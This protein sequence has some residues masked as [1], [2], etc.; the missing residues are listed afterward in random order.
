M[1]ALSFL[2]DFPAL[3]ISPRR[4]GAKMLDFSGLPKGLSARTFDIRNKDRV[5]LRQE[6][7]P[8][9]MRYLLLILLLAAGCESV[10]GPLAPRPGTR[11]DDPSLSIA[12]QQRQGRDRIGLP[13]NSPVLPP[14]AGS[15]PGR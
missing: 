8:S 3:I 14:E 1:A 7:K 2:S 10:R 12:E 15:R 9:K 11:V 6:R 13:D 4:R 5:R